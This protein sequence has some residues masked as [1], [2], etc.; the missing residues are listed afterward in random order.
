MSNK[1]QGICAI[2]ATLTAL[3]EL[4]VLYEVTPG[5]LDNHHPGVLR[6]LCTLLFDSH[7]RPQQLQTLT[8]ACV[9][10]SESAGGISTRVVGS[11]D[12]HVYFPF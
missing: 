8:Y 7:T 10:F 4:L 12:H 3:S 5:A 2:A 6:N 1:S 9:N 11:F